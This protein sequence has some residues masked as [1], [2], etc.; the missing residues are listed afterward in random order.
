MRLIENLKA[1]TIKWRLEWSEAG[2]G[3]GGMWK[4]RA[5]WWRCSSPDTWKLSCGILSTFAPTNRQFLP[6][7]KWQCERPRNFLSDHRGFTIN[8]N[9]LVFELLPW[10][11]LVAGSCSCLLWVT[12]SHKHHMIVMLRL[13][14]RSVSKIH[15][16]P[17]TQHFK[18]GPDAIQ[19]QN[20]K[21]KYAVLFSPK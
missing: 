12:V 10:F 17:R 5:K 21:W 20:S 11:L 14:L 3:D 15:V 1:D 16:L 18:R 13:E 8:R 6:F 7:L 19:C 4:F 2:A 9:P